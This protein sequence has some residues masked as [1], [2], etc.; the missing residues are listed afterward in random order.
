M[1]RVMIK[2]TVALL[3]RV[4]N[5]SIQVFYYFP[6]TIIVGKKKLEREEFNFLLSEGYLSEYKVDSFGK[7]YRLSNKAEQLIYH[8]VTTR[9]F[10]SRKKIIVIHNQGSLNFVS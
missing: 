8:T 1:N 5:Y 10:H 7:I 2:Q 6:D 9:Q 3:V 4:Y